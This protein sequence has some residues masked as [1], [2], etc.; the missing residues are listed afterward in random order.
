V[1]MAA[2][3]ALGGCGSAPSASPTHGAVIG[4]GERDF[5]IQAPQHITAGLVTIRDHNAGPEKHELIIV[6]AASTQL[7]LRSDG[8]TVDEDRI[9]PRT[10]VSIPGI[11]PGHTQDT[12]LRLPPGH[13]LLFCNM[14]GHFRGGMHT[15]L[16]VS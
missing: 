7:P 2:A 9:K 12:R 3:A 6:R 10:V 5:H 16:V 15:E 11:A 14:A 4:I 8:L 1:T 13:Y